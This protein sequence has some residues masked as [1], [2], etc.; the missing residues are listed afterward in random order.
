MQNLSRNRKC[1]RR[2]RKPGPVLPLWLWEDIALSINQEP[3]WYSTIK[4]QHLQWQK[5]GRKLEY[6]GEDKVYE[7]W[8][9]GKEPWVMKLRRQKGELRRGRAVVWQYQCQ[10][11]WEEVGKWFTETGNYRQV[12]NKFWFHWRVAICS[13]EKGRFQVRD[14]MVGLH[15]WDLCLSCIQGEIVRTTAVNSLQRWAL[16]QIT[17]DHPFVV[18]PLWRA[19]RVP[20]QDFPWCRNPTGYVMPWGNKEC[21]F[22]CS[23]FK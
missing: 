10:E 7:Y 16:L 21:A 2:Q 15:R 20:T 4:L 9:M 12:D 1:Y 13:C 19:R 23:I 22:M 5:R 6:D 14:F 17:R 8:K 11:Q 3:G 18:M